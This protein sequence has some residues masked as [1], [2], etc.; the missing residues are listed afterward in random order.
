MILRDFGRTLRKVNCSITAI[1]VYQ[2]SV[3]IRLVTILTHRL[4]VSPRYYSRAPPLPTRR[5]PIFF[6]DTWFC[7]NSP[8]YLLDIV[9]KFVSEYSPFTSLKYLRYSHL[10]V[11]PQTIQWLGPTRTRTC[12]IVELVTQDY[13]SRRLV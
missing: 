6:W 13:M 5:I 1:K 11:P 10:F 8:C 4:R 9:L 3:S 7:S 12:S 2:N